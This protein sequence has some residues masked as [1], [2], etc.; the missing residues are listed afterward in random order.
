MPRE[1]S[2][3]EYQQWQID[4]Q[5]AGLANEVWEDP[6]LGP[7]AK[8][9][10]KR[11]RPG[12]QIP[13]HDIRMEMRDGFAKME[14]AREEEKLAERQS[15]EDEY[16]KGQ[17]K[18]IQDEYGYT[19]DGI[20]DLEKMM[21]EKNIGDYEVAATYHAAKNPKAAEPQGYKDPYW[22][23]TKSTTFQEIA[24]DPEAWG[25]DEIVK[26]LQNDQR[27]SRNAF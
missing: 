1:I 19:D 21:L 8:E 12:V 20:K 14:K 18:K 4:K 11:K 15:K 27:R 9:L 17:R 6:Q 26:A 2:D 5:I 3:A 25:K 22:N 13:D 23:H 10:L 16:W 7:A 24:K